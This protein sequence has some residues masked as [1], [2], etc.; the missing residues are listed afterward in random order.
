MKIACYIRNTT[1][2]EQVRATLIRSGFEPA[3]YDSETALLRSLQ[4]NTFDL[5]VIDIAVMP[6]DDDSIFSWLNF[7]T[8]NRTPTLVL[9]PLRNAELA[10]LAL[11][12]GAD[13]FVVRPYE[14]IELVARINA[15]LRRCAPV[16]IR[17]TIEYA[18]FSLNRENAKFTYL[19]RP[20]SLTSREFSMAWLFFSSPGIY[21]SRETIGAVIWSADSEV[22]GRTIEQHVYKLR[23]KLVVDGEPVVMIRT[24][25]SQGYRL[26]MCAGA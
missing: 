1:V 7:R 14:P 12:S 8:G 6:R 3:H 4:R 22:A 23:K 24:A 20:I 25:Y 18:G 16:N 9:S 15:L 21:I 2:F 10:A 19:D 17:R 11:D 5:I 26:E 13:D